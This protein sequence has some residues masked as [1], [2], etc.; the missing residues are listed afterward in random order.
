MTNEERESI[1]REIKAAAVAELQY[2]LLVIKTWATAFV[3]ELFERAYQQGLLAGF[4]AATFPDQ[5]SDYERTKK[6]VELLECGKNV[7]DRKTV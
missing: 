1:Y 6:V 5:C 2:E 4:H 7:V 3:E